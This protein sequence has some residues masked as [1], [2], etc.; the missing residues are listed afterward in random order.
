MATRTATLQADSTVREYLLKMNVNDETVIDDV[1]EVSEVLY[2]DLVNNAEIRRQR[3][4]RSLPVAEADL[5]RTAMANILA[6]RP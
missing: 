5:F 6:R 1:M 2:K 3:V 4:E